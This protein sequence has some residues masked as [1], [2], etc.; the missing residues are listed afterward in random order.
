MRH[1]EEGLAV[2]TAAAKAGSAGRRG[3]GSRGTLACRRRSGSGAATGARTRWAGCSSGWRCRCSSATR[4]SRGWRSSRSCGGC[5]PSSRPATRRTVERRVREWKAVHGPEREVVF[6]QKHRPG[7]RGY[8]DFTAMAKLGVT[9]AGEP[10]PHLLYRLRFL[11]IVNS[12]SAGGA[13][14]QRLRQAVACRST[15]SE[16]PRDWRLTTIPCCGDWT[17]GVQ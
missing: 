4:G 17:K 2:E 11:G 9:V 12:S 13:A 8:S 1:R 5:I 16:R 7:R 15:W 3:T 14:A 6:V 10:L